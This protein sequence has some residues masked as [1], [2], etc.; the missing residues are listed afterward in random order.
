MSISFGL[1]PIAH[2]LGVWG[3]IIISGFLRS[4]TIAL[5]SIL[6]FEIK[7]VGST[8]GGTATGLVSTMGMF[9]AFFAPPL[10]NSFA[11]TNLGSPFVFWALL[12]AF[13]LP[14]LFFIKER[15]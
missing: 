6:T 15:R 10:G 12:S 11:D 7:E 4:G 9:G 8:Y 3:L 1:L 14:W 5:L 13:A 2:G